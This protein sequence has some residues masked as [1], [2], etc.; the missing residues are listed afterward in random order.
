MH[1]M[2]L[3]TNKAI[4]EMLASSCE[5]LMK[6]PHLVASM[7]QGAMVGVSRRLLE[8]AAPEKQLEPFRQELISLVGA[9]LEASAAHTSSSYSLCAS[10]AVRRGSYGEKMVRPEGFEPPTY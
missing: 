6:D 8:S 2:G 9:Y 3:R 4:V 10:E 1:Q 5:P 7:L